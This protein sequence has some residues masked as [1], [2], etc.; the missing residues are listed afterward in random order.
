MPACRSTPPPALDREM[1]A[2]VPPDARALAGIH[3]NQIRASPVLRDLSVN[4][5]PLLDP[6]RDASTVL[7]VYNGKDLLVVGRGE[8]HTTPPG[9]TLLAPQLAVTGPAAA[10]RAAA[11]QHAAGR[12]G[13]AALVNQAETVARQPIWVV[14]ARGT[15]LPLSGNAV[16]V[17]RLLDMAD[18]TTIAVGGTSGLTL[19]ATGICRSADEARKLEETLRGLLS[20]VGAATRDR[21]LAAVLASVQVNREDVRVHADLTGNPETIARMLRSIAR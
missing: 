9:A 20:L 5:L 14:V 16:N 19:Q 17:S 6:A 7:A 4:W 3:L 11:A 13:A 2:C 1:A 10:V 18:Y 8:F 15:M 21:D 12:P